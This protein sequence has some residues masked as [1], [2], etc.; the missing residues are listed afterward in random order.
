MKKPRCGGQRIWALELVECDER[1][2]SLSLAFFQSKNKYKIFPTYVK[3]I[4]GSVTYYIEVKIYLK[5]LIQLSLQTITTKNDN[6]TKQ[7]KTQ[8]TS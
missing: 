5:I 6:K 7:T 2:L 8:N 3:R 1:V 4:I